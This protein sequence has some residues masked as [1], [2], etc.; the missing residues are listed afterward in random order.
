M[1]SIRYDWERRLKPS[2]ILKKPEIAKNKLSFVI[3][4]KVGKS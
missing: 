2:E 3:D 4:L 1:E